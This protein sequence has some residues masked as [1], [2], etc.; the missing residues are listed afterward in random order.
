[1][2]SIGRVIQNL[3]GNGSLGKGGQSL[4]ADELVHVCGRVQRVKEDVML[5]LG[6]DANDLVVG[7]IPWKGNRGRNA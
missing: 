5:G 1:V 6:T 3:V 7:R 4:E 2:F